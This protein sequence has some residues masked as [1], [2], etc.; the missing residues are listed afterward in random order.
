MYANSVAL[1]WRVL[2]RSGTSQASW[3]SW[4]D[5]MNCFAAFATRQEMEVLCITPSLST[6][7]KQQDQVLRDALKT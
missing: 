4:F 7:T 6:T 2:S 1:S 3:K 5:S